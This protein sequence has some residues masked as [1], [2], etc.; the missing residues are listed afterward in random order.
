M[1]VGMGEPDEGAGLVGDGDGT[2]SGVEDFKT[3]YPNKWYRRYVLFLLFLIATLQTTDRNIPAILLP[4]ISPEF[5]MTDADAGMLNGAAFVFI[6]ALATI[7]LA[8]I[9]DMCGRKYLLAVSLIVWS[10]LTSLSGLSQNTTQLCFLRVGIGL[11]EA[12]CTP[13]A[14]SLI[15]VMYGPGQRASAMAMQQL[16]LA[17]GAAAANFIG[18]MLIDS[19]G[20]RGVFGVL[21]IPGFVLAAII[22]LTL[23]DPPV[24]QSMGKYQSVPG[25]EAEAGGK[26]S[27]ANTAATLTSSAFW[28]EMWRGVKETF[29]HLR[30]RATFI[31]LSIG[32]MIQVGVGLSI[33]AFLPIF[34]VRSHDMTVKNAGLSMAQVGGIFG[35]VGI[36]TGGLVGDWLVQRSGDQRWMLWF[37][38]I[39]NIIAAPLMVVAVLIKSRTDSIYLSGAGVALF[40]V[41]V[42]P[43]GAIVQSLVPNH[44]RATAAGFFGVLANLVGG[45]C[46]PLFIGWLSDRLSG[47]YGVDSIRYAL[48][49]SM[50]FCLWGQVHWYLASRAMPG[51][52]LEKTA[53]K[54]P[55]D[56][57]AVG[58]GGG[59]AGADGDEE[60][61]RD[62]EG[63][64]GG[65]RGGGGT[66]GSLG[67]GGGAGRR[68]GGDGTPK[69]LAR[70]GSDL[71]FGV[72]STLS[73]RIGD[74]PRERRG[75]T[76]YG[77]VV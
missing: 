18:G 77:S 74:E 48:A 62:V 40:M 57:C 64:R 2:S 22:V 35:A 25:D 53:L 33:M 31:H 70:Q 10:T 4:K 6:Y 65:A 7:P 20:W 63:G 75:T 27:A 5:N 50:I 46:G 17:V 45:S 39:C 13:A 11:G 3:C 54:R 56:F 60:A 1:G 30:K 8:R 51:D 28:A 68:R 76:H 34:L 44:M 43:P 16:G 26:P 73:I 41:M 24:E 23:E 12:G 55:R 61:A 52:I 72:F 21:G 29:E 37:I 19:L 66:Y 14:Q 71:G 15:A 32:V 58:G 49:Y 42:G 47:R 36:V 69:A 38:L 9:A 59:G 67:G